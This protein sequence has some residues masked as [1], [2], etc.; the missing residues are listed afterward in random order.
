ML[1]I[2]CTADLQNSPCDPCMTHC[3]LHWCALCQEH[4]EM[5]GRLADN[6]AVPMT[7]VNPPPVQEMKSENDDEGTTSSSNMGNGQTNLEM[8]AL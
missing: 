1:L 5:K 7:I 3:C 6:F 8:Q 2:N 4:R